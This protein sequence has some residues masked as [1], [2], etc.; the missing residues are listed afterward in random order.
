L[1]KQPVFSPAQLEQHGT[2][3]S[4]QM[5]MSLLGRLKDAGILVVTRESSGRRPQI[6][7]FAELVDLCEGHQAIRKRKVKRPGRR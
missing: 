6:L 1:F 3:P 7:T 2:L 4:K 5:T